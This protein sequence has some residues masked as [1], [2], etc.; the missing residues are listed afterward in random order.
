ME[1]RLDQSSE[2]TNAALE[3]DANDWTGVTPTP[4]EQRLE[5]P[6]PKIIR[7]L[8]L[9]WE[10][11][12]IAG[13]AASSQSNVGGTRGSGRRTRSETGA[14]YQAD[15]ALQAK[16]GERI[17]DLEQAVDQCQVY[18]QE[19]KDQ[20]ANQ[21]FLEAQLA[22][23]EETSQIQQQA[24]ATLKAKLMAQESQAA[25]L[26]RVLQQN[27]SLEAKLLEQE[28]RAQAQQ[29]EIEHLQGQ[30]NQ[31]QQD[32]SDRQTLITDLETKLHRTKEAL[33][34]QQDVISAL[35]KAQGPDSEK[36]RVIQGL[37]KNL[38]SIQSKFEALE[39]E[40]S[41]QLM[42]QAK[43]QHS[44]QELEGQRGLYQ[45]RIQQLELQVAEMQEQ[46]LQ[47]AK[48]ASEYEAAVQ[49]WK[50]NCQYAEQS[51]LQL[52]SVLEQILTDRNFLE[53]MT[54]SR[55]DGESNSEAPGILESS[56]SVSSRFLRHLKIDLPAFLNLKRSHRS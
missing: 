34:G 48:Q 36:N 46:I 35:Q 13:L 8:E 28:V 50:D 33:V 6:Q 22:A 18:I 12:P 38:L 53:L 42:L 2:A 55:D 29:V 26:D 24:I 39:T 27:Q 32:L 51:V 17:R 7:Q 44:C 45:D 19:L 47:Q 23:T 21:E 5:Q 37:S 30:L 9:S 4:P 56:D 1:D 10:G 20:L 43:L 25:Q 54:A 16:Q 41:S 40:Y 49:H 52:K 11:Q 15:Q 3:G 14:S 31:D